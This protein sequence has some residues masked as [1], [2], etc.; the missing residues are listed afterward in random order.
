MENVDHVYYPVVLEGKQKSVKIL[1][2][3]EIFSVSSLAPNSPQANTPS[4]LVSQILSARDNLL[5]ICL[6]E[7]KITEANE[8]IRV[9]FNSLYHNSK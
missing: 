9:P 7:G 8:V 4:P 2:S 1:F 6:K 3:I 5:A